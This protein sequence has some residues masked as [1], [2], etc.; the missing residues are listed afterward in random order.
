LV[1]VFRPEDCAGNLRLLTAIQRPA[2]RSRITADGLVYGSGKDVPGA[3]HLLARA[4]AETP[5]QPLTRRQSAALELL[6]H[7]AMPFWLLFD[8][9]GRLVLSLPT[10]STPEDHFRMIEL[11]TKITGARR[12]T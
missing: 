5:I 12:E 8:P 11:L 1:Y 9:E 7:R 10:P 6:G 2:L 3:R 4:G